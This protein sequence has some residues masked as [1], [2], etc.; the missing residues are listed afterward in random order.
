MK[1]EVGDAAVISAVDATAACLL[2]KDSL[3]LLLPPRNC[4]ANAAL[5]S[6]LL[7]PTTTPDVVELDPAVELAESNGR[8]AVG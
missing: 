1:D 3:D 5:A 2:D 8:R 4:L 7:S 6:P